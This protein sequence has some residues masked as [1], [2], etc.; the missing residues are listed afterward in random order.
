MQHALSFYDASTQQIFF[1]S[2]SP[3]AAADRSVSGKLI[4]KDNKA[5]GYMAMCHFYYTVCLTMEFGPRE[6]SDATEGAKNMDQRPDRPTWSRQIEFTLAGIGCAVGLG[7][8][9]R[10]P[11]LCY[12]SGGGEIKI[13]ELYVVWKFLALLFPVFFLYSS[14]QKVQQVTGK[15]VF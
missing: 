15:S 9:W 4:I 12:R 1:F 2:G 6:M 5:E 11:Y 13:M 8:I 7:N 14:V 3:S 10:F